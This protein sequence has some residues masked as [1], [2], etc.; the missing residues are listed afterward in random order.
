MKKFINSVVFFLFTLPFGTL[1]G[2]LF[3]FMRLFGFLE[4]KGFEN[5]PKQKGKIVLVSNH[6]YKG[7]Q[8]LL[9]GLFFPRYLFQP[10]YGPWN[11]ADKANYYDK[12]KYWLMRPRLI[13]V[14]RSLKK[15]DL[16]SFEVALAVLD[17]GANI[18]VFPEGG[19]TSK[20]TDFLTSK[21][22]K[23]I[24]LPLKTSFAI[25]AAQPGTITLPVWCEFDGW[26]MR[27]TI[28]QQQNF[29]GVQR[30]EVTERIKKILL[31]LADET[32]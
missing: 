6:P 15:G 8:F 16:E 28:G 4:L 31:E 14:D 32:G 24:R 12:P 7:E 19:R 11:L 22:G 13:P 23:K 2:V 1:V 20:G 5:F 18:I 26:L 25:L 10:K 21:K 9:I 3:W 30:K 29:E 27:V 17:S